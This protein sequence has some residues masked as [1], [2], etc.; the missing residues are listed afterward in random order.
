M[1]RIVQDGAITRKSDAI[2]GLGFNA[3]PNGASTQ[4]VAANAARAELTI[5]NDS[6]TV[7]Y[8]ALGVAAEAS[9][10]LRLNANGGSW[11][12]TAYTGAVFAFHSGAAAKTLV[13]VEV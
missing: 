13:F 2:N 4:I 3:V 9:K 10:G 1:A 5:V 6:D 11:T 12:S 8:L 7:I